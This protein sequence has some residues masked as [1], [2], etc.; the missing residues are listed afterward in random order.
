MAAID[1]AIVQVSTTRGQ[2]LRETNTDT[3]ENKYA[4]VSHPKTTTKTTS[5]VYNLQKGKNGN[6]G[7][8]YSHPFEDHLM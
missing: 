6:H 7:W 3:K 4:E 8:D 2:E 1:A 5:Q